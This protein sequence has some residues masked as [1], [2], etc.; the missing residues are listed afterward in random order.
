MKSIICILLVIFLSGCATCGR[1]IDRFS[2][3]K[4]QK[5]V[6]TKEDVIK[7]FGQPDSTYFDK[8]N[9]LIYSYYASKVNSS[10]WNFIPVVNL[11]HSEMKMKMQWLVIVFSKD[12]I[13]EEYSFT[14]SNK[15]IQYGIIP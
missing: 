15:P 10:V 7:K 14:D 4:M 12:S 11:V 6:T 3:E 2:V 8:D 13:V 1:P 5:G 9:R